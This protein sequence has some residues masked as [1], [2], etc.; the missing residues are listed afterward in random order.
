[1]GQMI[2]SDDILT[3]KDKSP[4]KRMQRDRNED[5]WSER[6]VMLLKTIIELISN[7]CVLLVM[8]ALARDRLGIQ[9][10]RRMVR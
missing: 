7:L 9:V 5:D 2:L 10:S 1:M 6:S 4:D 3:E 8:F